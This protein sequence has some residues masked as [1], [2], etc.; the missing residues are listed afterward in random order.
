MKDPALLDKALK[1]RLHFQQLYETEKA[2]REKSDTRG[3]ELGIRYSEVC[4][5]KKQVEETL[6]EERRE[7]EQLEQALTALQKAGISVWAVP[8]M[9]EAILRIGQLTNDS[10]PPSE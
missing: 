6:A 8:A 2:A 7:H 10:Y 9:A 4:R 3:R 5:A 1:D